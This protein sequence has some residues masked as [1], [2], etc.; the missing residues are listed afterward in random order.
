MTHTLEHPIILRAGE[1]DA[2]SLAAFRESH[3]IR[4]EI[5]LFASQLGELYLTEHAPIK[6]QQDRE[7]QVQTYLKQTL[8]ETPELQGNWVYY[9]WSGRFV[10]M[11]GEE[12]YFMLRTNRNRE[13]VST[14]EQTR[15]STANIA[16]AGLSIGGSMATTLAQS[17]I[18]TSFILAEY[19]ELDSTNLN[20]L[21]ARV[22]QVGAPKMC[23]TGQ[24][25]Y[26]LDPYI[27]INAFECGLDED[28]LP[29]FLSGDQTPSI[30]IDAIDDFPM[31]V[32]IRM[33]ARAL[34]IPVFMATNVHDRM[35]FDIERYDL[36]AEL[37][38][39]NGLVLED[40]LT[41]ILDG[42]MTQQDMQ[43]Y[44][45]EIVGK[46]HVSERAFASVME[47]GKTL[48]GRP[49]LMSTITATSGIAT[50]LL[51]EVLL[52]NHTNSGRYVTA[53]PELFR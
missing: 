24:T 19:D 10:H 9:P 36:D 3:E 46:E 11:I 28:T 23:V 22:D 43:R 8:G 20:R 14:E 13:L 29:Q 2:A 4:E 37:P 50:Y 1:Y 17:G 25:L 45:V 44:A 47:V 12:A 38:L 40:I 7:E 48:G 16:I 39:F 6:F 5:D 18:G 51:R 35:L 27:Q 33:Q 30:V 21:R 32:R 49:Q 41:D 34:G 52:G 31:K 15:L 53:I 26:E 42:K